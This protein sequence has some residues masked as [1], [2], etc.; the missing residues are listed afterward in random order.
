[1]NDDELV[2]KPEPEIIDESSIFGFL[3]F[4]LNITES[5]VYHGDYLRLS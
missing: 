2:P 5:E 3:F 4:I 1:M